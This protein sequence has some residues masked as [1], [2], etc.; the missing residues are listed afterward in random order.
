MSMNLKWAGKAFAM[1]GL[2]A[3][4]FLAGCKPD[5]TVTRPVA[6]QN[7]DSSVFTI[8]AGS[9]LKDVASEVQGF[10]K[11]Q[12]MEV[13][14]DYSGSLDA[15]DRLQQPHSYDAV[16]LSHGKYPRL[17]PAVAK[18]IK[19]SD[20]TM[21]S[22][23]VLGIKPS[24]LKELGWSAQDG[25]VS[26]KEVLQAVKAGKLKLAMTNP[27][28]SNTGFVTLVGLAAEFSGKG[29]AL[30]VQDI[31]EAKLKEFFSGVSLTS[32]SSGD[33]AEKF[34]A[35]PEKADAL[36]NYEAT[37]RSLSSAGVALTVLT[38]KEGVITADYPLMLLANSKKQ[39][40]Y[41]KLVEYIRQP[42]TQKRIAQ[43]TY[44]TPLTG[45]SDAVV[46]ELPFPGAL[47]V[48]DALL[49][50]YLNQYSRPSTS[51]FV[52]DVSGSMRRD[53]RMNELKT[54]M[55]ALTN[56]DGSVSGRF[57][58]F[59]DRESIVVTPFNHQVQERMSLA[60]GEKR[61]QNQATLQ[62]LDNF[63]QGLHADGGTAIF[64]ALASVYGDA[65]K[66]L[67]E[68]AGPVSIVLM[69]DGLNQD[70]MTLG[71]FLEQVNALGTPRVPVYAILYGEA[72][73]SELNEL[74]SATGGK[75]FDARKVSLSGVLKSI[76]NYQ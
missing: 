26:W 29:D 23:V 19:A 1:L 70:G 74:A 31:P 59:R 64:S 6:D 55:H 35:N 44:R 2:A 76:R 18:Q 13:R 73:S 22:R 69:T 45:G 3:T 36:V 24:K 67:K 34:K 12:G 42:D 62:S 72:S 21:Y 27:A 37:L 4:V 32:G 71:K 48:V 38:P 11:A 60:L 39:A 51:Y 16:W 14:F 30:E 53:G 9:E 41:E 33:L 17:V 58:T 43:A 68:N 28:G 57:S 61:S 10:A 20:K 15:V 5:S 50:G 46:N 63:V 75:V 54:A 66:K 40:F 7:S 56:G 65:Q 49:E 25:Q 52:L 47:K 8:L